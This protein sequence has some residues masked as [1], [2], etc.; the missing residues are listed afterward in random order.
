MFYFL[1]TLETT[2][3]EYHIRHE[4]IGVLHSNTY[5]N[6]DQNIA[7]T[8]SRRGTK[9]VILTL[10]VVMLWAAWV[11]ITVGCTIIVGA[12]LIGLSLVPFCG[13]PHSYYSTP[14]LIPF[15]YLIFLCTSN[16]LALHF[17]GANCAFAQGA[18]YITE[19]LGS[20]TVSIIV[21]FNKINCIWHFL[22]RTQLNAS[23]LWVLRP[24]A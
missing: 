7:Q 8:W 11:H 24:S 16:A 20:R 13:S 3:Q 14:F 17:Q 12:A 1:A 4:I 10:A 23:S 6:I 19:F 15:C 22:L 2:Y 5:T 18:S 9:W 21:P